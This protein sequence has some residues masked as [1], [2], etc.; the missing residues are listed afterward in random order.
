LL[1]ERHRLDTRQKP[2]DFVIQNVS[3]IIRASNETNQSFTMLMQGVAAL[4][5]LVGGVGILATMLLSVK[6]RRLE[7]GLRMAVGVRSKDVFMY[8]LFGGVILSVSGGLIG[9][10]SGIAGSLLL[11]MLTTLTIRI[12]YIAAGTS[13]VISACIGIFF[14]SYPALRASMVTPVE[15][16]QS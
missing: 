7:I 3:T 2:D 14:G 8:F 15:S 10:M 1:R 12:S 5:L 9:L 13:I 16:L 11:A 6:E 4:S